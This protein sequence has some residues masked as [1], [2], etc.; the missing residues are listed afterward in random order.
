V[1]AYGGVDVEIHI[2]LTSALFGA[3]WSASRPGRFTPGERAPGTHW[4]R[5]WVDPRAGLDDLEKRK[6]LTIP[7]PELR[8]LGRP[9]RSQ[10]LYRLRYPGSYTYLVGNHNTSTHPCAGTLICTHRHTH[11]YVYMSSTYAVTRV[12]R[13]VYKLS[14]SLKSKVLVDWLKNRYSYYHIIHKNASNM[15]CPKHES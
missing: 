6:F 1:K 13:L 12:L 9:A 7:G 11:T 4:I 10:S 15:S 8:P 3:G 2:F 14:S 5:G